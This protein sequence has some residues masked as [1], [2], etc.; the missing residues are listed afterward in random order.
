VGHWEDLNEQ[1]SYVLDVRTAAEYQEGHFSNA[2]NIPVDTLRSRIAEI[3]RDR[4]IWAHCL[5][6]QRSYYAA[7]ILQQHG[8]KVRNIS[9]GFLLYPA[10]ER[11]KAPT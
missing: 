1:D 5:V 11:F 6:G 7:R 10:V 9:G 2:A 3:P 4:E 8:F